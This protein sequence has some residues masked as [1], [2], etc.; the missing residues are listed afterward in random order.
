MTIDEMLKKGIAAVNT[1]QKTEARRLLMHVVEQDEC[2]EVAWLW[3]SGAV[4]TN[5]ERRVCLENVL[6]I[7]PNNGM[8][9]RGLESLIAQEG[10]R[11][12]S[13]WS[14]P[15]SL[16]EPA[17]RPDEKPMQ[18]PAKASVPGLTRRE[19]RTGTYRRK[20][21]AQQQTRL[22][23][24]IG[25]GTLMLA[26]I[27]FAGI[28]WAF[29]SGMLQLGS[30][31]P[32]AMG[33]TQVPSVADVTSM[34]IPSPTR[35]PTWT[36]TLRPTNAPAPTRT[37]RPTNTPRPTQTPFPPTPTVVPQKLGP[38]WNSSRDESYTV[39]ISLDRVRFRSGSAFLKPKLGQVYVTVDVTIKNLGPSPLRSIGPYDFQVRDANGALRDSSWHPYYD[40]CQM[41][42]VDLGPNGSASGCFG[43][44]VP[45]EGPLELIYA[46]YQ[47]EALRPGRYLSFIIRQ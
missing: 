2:N 34:P 13:V 47:Y 31:A 44:E 9:K 40:E 1:G 39:Q 23:I 11:P 4:D 12:L 10:V 7:N 3:L 6:A 21:A 45:I 29:D 43:F 26:C 32:V 27:T 25:A 22:M 35:I 28:W 19:K 8:A 18:S 30:A 14:S 36:P 37:P 42:I 46:P 16:A 38:I 20:K 33:V 24:G 41:D 15:P 5:K 17:A